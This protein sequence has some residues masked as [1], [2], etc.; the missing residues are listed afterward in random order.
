MVAQSSKPVMWVSVSVLTAIPSES[1]ISVY[2]SPVFAICSWRL[3]KTSCAFILSA[4]GVS[5]SLGP[6]ESYWAFPVHFTHGSGLVV[7]VEDPSHPLNFEL[8]NKRT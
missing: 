3:G 1:T 2:L 4:R 7:F 6:S 5:L 8:G